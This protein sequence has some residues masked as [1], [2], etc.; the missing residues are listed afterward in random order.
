M[1]INHLNWTCTT[2]VKGCAV[3]TALSQ[4]PLSCLSGIAIKFRGFCLI[5][6]MKV[7]NGAQRCLPDRHFPKC[8]FPEFR[9]PQHNS[10]SDH[11]IDVYTYPNCGMLCSYALVVKYVDRGKHTFPCLGQE[12]YTSMIRSGNM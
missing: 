9:Y 5:F 11:N 10:Y 8:C 6:Y 1:D 12:T 4:N 2:W 3:T 7:W